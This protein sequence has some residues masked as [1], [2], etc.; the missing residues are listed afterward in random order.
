MTTKQLPLPANSA[1]R[2]Q[3]TQV[4]KEE[5]EDV[6]EEKIEEEE[7][8]EV[9]EEEKGWWCMTADEMLYWCRHQWMLLSGV[10]QVSAQLSF[11]KGIL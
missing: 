1:S 7:E 8:E 3:D 5:E 10:L 9:E 11:R 4:E 2:K 6:E